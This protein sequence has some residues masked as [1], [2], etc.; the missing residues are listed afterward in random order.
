M[1]ERYEIIAGWLAMKAFFGW[2]EKE[3]PTQETDYL[4]RYN[5]ALIGNLLSLLIGLGIGI[6]ARSIAVHLVSVLRTLC[7]QIG[8]IEQ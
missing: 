2:I 4:D 3:R 1:N 7:N 6:A 5:S 8:T